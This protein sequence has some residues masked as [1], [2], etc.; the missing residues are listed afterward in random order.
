MLHVEVSTSHLTNRSVVEVVYLWPRVAFDLQ[1]INSGRSAKIA[2]I[3][4]YY[5]LY[6]VESPSLTRRRNCVVLRSRLEGPRHGLWTE[7]RQV[8]LTPT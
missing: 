1:I 6:V 3:I 2:R 5:L 8:E 4:K 7:L